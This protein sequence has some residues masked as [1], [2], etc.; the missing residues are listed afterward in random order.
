[1]SLPNPPPTYEPADQQ[2]LRAAVAGM[3]R[4]NRK[5]GQDIDLRNARIFLYAPNGSRW[6][7]VVSNA[8]ALSTVAA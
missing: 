8:G 7:I 4:Q 3:D 2:A 6:Q 1:M 5:I